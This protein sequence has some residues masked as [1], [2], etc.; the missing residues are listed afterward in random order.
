MQNRTVAPCVECG[1]Q[2]II[3]SKGRCVKCNGRE[4]KRRSREDEHAAP[5]PGLDRSQWRDHQILCKT[6]GALSGVFAV[7][8]KMDSDNVND[9][10]MSRERRETVKLFCQDAFRL[11]DEAQPVDFSVFED[12][13]TQVDR[14]TSE[15]EVDQSTSEEEKGPDVN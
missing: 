3:V 14:S 8:Q 1:E 15:S 6:R 4:R 12:D 11:L 5:I 9:R 7:M 2:R 13:E 10:V